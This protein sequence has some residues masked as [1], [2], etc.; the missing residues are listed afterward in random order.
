MC[1][2]CCKISPR[3]DK[4]QTSNF[5]CNLFIIW[6]IIISG[7]FYFITL[8]CFPVEKSLIATT[9]KLLF[10]IFDID[11][12]ATLGVPYQNYPLSTTTIKTRKDLGQKKMFVAKV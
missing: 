2:G 12:Q 6:G 11:F 4:K 3:P 5:E 8:F 1:Y 9:I 10:F 7:N